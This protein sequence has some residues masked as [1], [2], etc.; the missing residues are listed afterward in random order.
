MLM[1]W[2]YH[3]QAMIYMVL[4]RL[5]LESKLIW[6]YFQSNSTPRAPTHSGKNLQ[7]NERESFK[8]SLTHL[9]LHKMATISQSTF[10]NA[11]SWMKNFVFWFEFHWSLFLRV[12]L[13]IFHLDSGL[14]PIRRQAI[15]WTNA[16]PVHWRIY[17]A[18]GGD[19][20]THCDLEM[21]N[22]D[23]FGTILV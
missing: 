2:R 11:F 8:H 6:M 13:T 20:L 16:G 17:A 21:P 12:Q 4:T 23:R 14:A 3:S 5:T 7:K 10:W 19:E 18:L 22:G 9:P 1:Y 15:I